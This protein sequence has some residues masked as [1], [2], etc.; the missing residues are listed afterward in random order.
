M[1]ARITQRQHALSIYIVLVVGLMAAVVASRWI[2]AANLPIE[3]IVC[4][5]PLASVCLVLLNYKYEQTLATL[6]RYLSELERLNNSHLELPSYNTEIRWTT[7]AN[8]A[9]R[10]HDVACAVLVLCCNGIALGAFYQMYPE[11]F[12]FASPTVWFTS[13]V[14]LTSAGALLLLS[15]F[16]HRPRY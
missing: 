9:R 14:T 1:N 11:Q 5:F 7:R 3:W 2:E 6:R 4:G 16:S 15:R 12:K 13:L 8:N 10:F